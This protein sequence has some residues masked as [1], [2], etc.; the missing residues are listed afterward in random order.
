[1]FFTKKENEILLS[2]LNEEDKPGKEISFP[3]FNKENF[4]CA[5]S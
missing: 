4:Q 3:D 2:V 5:E 1:M